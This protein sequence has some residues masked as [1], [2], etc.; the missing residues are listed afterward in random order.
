MEK[1]MFQLLDE[2][3]KAKDARC[4]YY[5]NSKH[6]QENWN[7]IEVPEDP[8]YI[9]LKNEVKI[10]ENQIKSFKIDIT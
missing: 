3:K 10:I 9:R 5:W 6:C 7:K 1:N 4:E 2:L 8:E